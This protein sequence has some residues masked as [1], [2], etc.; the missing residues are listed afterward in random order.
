MKKALVVGASGLVGGFVLEQ[1]LHNPDYSEVTVLARTRLNINHPKLKQEIVSFDSLESV[2]M[3]VFSVTDVFSCLGTTTLNRS[4]DIT[5]YKKIEFDYPTLIAKKALQAG[6]RS[7]HYVS[8]IASS[9]KSF[10]KYSRLKGQ[11]ED[12]LKTLQ[13]Q[14]P[15]SLVVSYRPSFI[16]GP[17][18]KRRPLEELITPVWSLM[19]IFMQ[20]P[21][22]KLRSISAEKIAKAMI[23][24]AEAGKGFH[25][26]DGHQ[27]E[28]MAEGKFRIDESTPS[29]R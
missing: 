7:F 22:Q 5:P 18:K 19:E 11:T 21:L 4:G 8:A 20:G 10:L 16:T 1:L 15:K 23:F 28:L 25:L 6:A 17:R 26:V 13:S 12:V 24:Q 9:S 2:N 27:I 14:Y 29:P 3:T